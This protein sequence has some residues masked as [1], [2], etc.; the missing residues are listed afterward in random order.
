[1]LYLYASAH[2]PAPVQVAKAAESSAA[3]A[4][5]PGYRFDPSSGF[6]HSSESGMYWDASSGGFYSEGKWYSYDEA[7]GQFV[8]WK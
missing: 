7:A 5:P 3:V 4:P 6:Y 1:M 2:L 8:E